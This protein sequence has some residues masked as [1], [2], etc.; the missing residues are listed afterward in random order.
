MFLFIK[1]YR[2]KAGISVPRMAE[3]TGIPRR[4]IQALEE[5]GLPCVQ[6]QKDSGR[7]GRKN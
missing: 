1:E 3:L 6:R 2:L 7:F 4:T 5:R